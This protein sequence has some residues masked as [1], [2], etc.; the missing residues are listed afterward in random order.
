MTPAPREPYPLSQKDGHGTTTKYQGGCR[1]DECCEVKSAYDR[2]YR[3]AN[4]EK[5]REHDRLPHRKVQLRRDPAKVR[6]RNRAWRRFG[7][8]KQPCEMCGDP[9]TQIHHDD[10]DK[11]LEIRWL[12]LKCHGVVHRSSSPIRRFAHA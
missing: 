9:N 8:D 3:Q 1:C 2:A 12:C 7:K 5:V 4:L 6:A 11:P 10:Y